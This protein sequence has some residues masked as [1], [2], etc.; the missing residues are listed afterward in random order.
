MSDI[1]DLLAE[2]PSEFDT[3][4]EAVALANP[5]NAS[6]ATIVDPDELT[7]FLTVT[8]TAPFEAIDSAV[9]SQGYAAAVWQ[10]RAAAIS[11]DYKTAKALE[12]W[13]EWAGKINAR[14]K[15]EQMENI[16]NENSKM[17]MPREVKEIV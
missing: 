3:P 2:E 12:L 11:G 16:K 7:K 17:F 10:F 14:P 1:D 13:L 15:R 5:T 8:R 6:I 4:P 9:V